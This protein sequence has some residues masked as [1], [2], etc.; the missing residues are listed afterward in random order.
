[1]HEQTTRTP[2]VQCNHILFAHSDLV[3]EILYKKI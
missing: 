1:M 2:T 3:A